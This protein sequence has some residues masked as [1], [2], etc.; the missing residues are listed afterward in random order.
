MAKKRSKAKK[1][2][3]KRQPKQAK[4][5]QGP[6]AYFAV[7]AIFLVLLAAIVMLGNNNSQET[8]A[9]GQEDEQK[10]APPVSQDACNTNS[11]C[12]ITYC[13]GQD[14]RCVNTTTL[15]SYSKNCASYSDWVIETQVSGDCACV[16]GM[17]EMLK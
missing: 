8:Y 12:F 13:R 17:C 7:A 9:S 10:I 15:S 4:K 3:R 2:Q 6:M 16:D 11:Q 5:T 14:R 1:V